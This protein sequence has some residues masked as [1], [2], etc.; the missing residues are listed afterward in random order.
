MVRDIISISV[1]ARKGDVFSAKSDMLALGVFS[2][3][4]RAA[5]CDK[6]DKKLNGAITKLLKLGD[7]KGEEKTTSLL[8]ADGKI[9]SAR[10][11]LVGLGETKKAGVDTIRKA[12]A[13]AANKA[14][15]LKAKNAVLAVHQ[16]V[17]GMKGFPAELLGQAVAEG[18]YFGAY[19]YDEYVGKSKSERLKSVKAM[20][21][22]PNE[23]ILR[24]L[25]RGVK[26]S[27]IHI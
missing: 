27:L 11:L 25:S 18:A 10:V 12:A 22:E 3:G 16:D 15:E 14:V 5:F 20:L 8:Y 13:V 6:L 24:Q 2:D 19:R 1:A 17:V 7:F 21:L 9:G 4:K 23:K 26:L